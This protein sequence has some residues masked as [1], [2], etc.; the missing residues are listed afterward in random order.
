MFARY[1]DEEHETEKERLWLTSIIGK[2]SRPMCVL[3]KNY[4]LQPGWPL[5]VPSKLSA[6]RSW[7][8]LKVL[9]EGTFRLVDVTIGGRI[10]KMA[11]VQDVNPLTAYPEISCCIL[12][13]SQAVYS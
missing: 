11:G 2:T 6:N 1:W 7:F 9:Y 3:G 13:F 12:R 8:P 5:E 10:G 4:S